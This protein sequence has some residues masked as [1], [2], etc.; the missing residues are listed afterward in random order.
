MVEA[1]LAEGLS[2]QTVA[3]LVR[4]VSTMFADLTERP[5]ET[6]VTANPVQPTNRT[7]TAGTDFQATNTA[8]PAKFVIAGTWS[9]TL[10]VTGT[11]SGNI[12]LKMGP[13]ANPS[14][15]VDEATPSYSITIVVGLTLT[16]GIPWKLACEMPIGYFGRVVNAGAGTVAITRCSE[17]PE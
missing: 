2:P 8:R 13:S 1:K 10:T 5:V 11:V 6:G 3:H 12:Q 7:I 14:T 16:P 17:Y 4:L 15:V 9:T